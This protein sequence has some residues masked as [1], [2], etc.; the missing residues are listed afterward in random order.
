[1]TFSWMSGYY[2]GKGAA[3]R[4]WHKYVWP[5][6]LYGCVSY[7]DKYDQEGPCLP[8]APAPVGA[9]GYRIFTTTIGASECSIDGKAWWPK[10]KDNLC[11]LADKPKESDGK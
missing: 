9:T 7:V 1:M 2:F 5:G 10:R 8:M 6:S 11:Y 4:Y 3:D